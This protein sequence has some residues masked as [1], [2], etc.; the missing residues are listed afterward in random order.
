MARYHGLVAGLLLT[1]YGAVGAYG[2]AQDSVTV[3]R[4]RIPADWDLT[5]RKLQGSI[6]GE[7]G[8]KS[9]SKIMAGLSD[10]FP[11]VIF[12][13]WN[14]DPKSIKAKDVEAHLESANCNP[15]DDVVSKQEMGDYCNKVVRELQEKYR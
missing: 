1:L 11:F 15:K 9:G 5:I 2:Q 14:F 6:E 4:Y 3:G 8:N 12:N 10:R 7:N 13:E